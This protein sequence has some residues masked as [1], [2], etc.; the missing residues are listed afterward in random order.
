MNKPWEFYEEECNLREVVLVFD[1]VPTMD[2]SR[3]TKL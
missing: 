3:L 1:S 2:D